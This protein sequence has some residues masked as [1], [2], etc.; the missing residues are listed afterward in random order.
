MIW[1]YLKY[2]DNTA[3]ETEDRFLSYGNLHQVTSEIAS[4][5]P[6]RAL[7]FVLAGNTVGSLAGYAA[8]LNHG[9]V[10]LM[11]D[12]KIDRDLLADLTAR[13]RPQYLWAPE[14]ASDGFGTYEAVFRT[15]G[16]V[17]LKTNIPDPWPLH[18]DLALLINT[19]GSVGVPKLVRQSRR[20]ITANAQSIIE[21]L[22]I[23][24]SEKAVTSLPM[25][26]V[27][28]LSVIN[29]HLMAGAS[30]VVTDESC[31]KG[32]FWKLFNEK[33]V[34][35]FSGVPFM[36]EMLFK[37]RITKKS[38]PSLKTLTQAGGK[39][40][41]ELQQFFSQYAADNGKRFFVMYGASEA[42]SRMGYLPWQDALRK[43]GSMGIPIP[44]GRYELA[45]E[46]GNVITEAGKTGELVYYG[47]NVMM[48]YAEC[49]EDL[50]KADELHGRLLT[51]D[52]A[53]RDEDGYYYV[54]GRKKRFIKLLGKRLSLD[55]TE[56][57]LKKLFDTA[58]L[59]CAGTDDRL[60]VFVTDAALEAPVTEYL[61]KTALINPGLCRVRVIPEIPKNASGK[62]LY[63]KL[64]EMD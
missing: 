56:L 37:L 6:E 53:Y 57:R 26:Y 22:G 31:Y 8:F 10:P 30:I 28:G 27:Y 49:G 18:E 15:L 23:T 2:Q 63:G 20:N 24:E 64:N 7:V 32:A 58:D 55:E 40:S 11:L 1:D 5:I 9:I 36:Y 16:Y 21:Y 39:L 59:A 17:L 44:G 51:G 46:D 41:P 45:D 29:T 4:H 13:Y 54:A 61:T 43:S 42:T 14:E 47:E 3:V 52:M 25:N 50:A 33:Q 38:L 35:S 60:R 34:T 48:G 19:S 62:T 12:E